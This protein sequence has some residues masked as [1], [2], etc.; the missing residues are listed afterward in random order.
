M[1]RQ[2]TKTESSAKARGNTNKDS[3]EQA[4]DSKK[5]KKYYFIIISRYLFFIGSQDTSWHELEHTK[6]L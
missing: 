2:E 6:V 1:T 5:V 4:P 3:G